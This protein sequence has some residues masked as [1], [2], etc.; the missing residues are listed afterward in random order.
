M[1]GW[2]VLAATLAAYAIGC[3]AWA[4]YI[5]RAIKGQDIRE[6]GSGNAGG[7]NAGR[8]LGRYGFAAVA[9]LDALKG[10]AAVL[11]AGALGVA[12]WGMLPV[13]LAVVA[14]HIWPAQLHFRGGKGIA[15]MV[16]ALLF[17]D[18]LIPLILLGMV[19]LLFA[20]LRSITLAFVIALALLPLVLLAAGWPWPAIG[21]V[22]A[23]AAIV[24]YAHRAN[25]RARLQRRAGSP[26]S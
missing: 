5:V 13:L 9:V 17:Y 23:L 15:T 12:G 24:L 6:L 10:V 25:I 21:S 2:Q 18:Y 20:V 7:R 22:V 11:L 19:V 26:A 1:P 4:Y 8:V 16:G 3:I 14:G